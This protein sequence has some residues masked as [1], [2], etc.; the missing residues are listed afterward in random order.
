MYAQPTDFQSEGL[1]LSEAC[2][3]SGLGRTTIYRAIAAGELV[4]GKV[5][6]RTII[7]RE[8]LRQLLAGLPVLK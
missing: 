8:D 6:K 3:I 2:R 1:S 4:A 7:L 5:G